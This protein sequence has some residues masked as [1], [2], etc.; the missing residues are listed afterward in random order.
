MKYYI[1]WI[2]FIINV[3]VTANKEMSFSSTNVDSDDGNADA[4]TVA[5]CKKEIARLQL[6]IDNKMKQVNFMVQDQKNHELMPIYALSKI[7]LDKRKKEKESEI[8]QGNR[9]VAQ[10][11]AGFGSVWYRVDELIQSSEQDNK[12]NPDDVAIQKSYIDAARKMN[13]IKQTILYKE[14]LEIFKDELAAAT[15]L[16]NAILALPDPNYSEVTPMGLF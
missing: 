13:E 2:D 10:Q 3:I 6:D 11:T 15:K 12:N 4:L 14:L 8:A 1:H 16:Y 5:D 7:T 9:T